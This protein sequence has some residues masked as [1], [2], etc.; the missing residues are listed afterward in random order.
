[1]LL[2]ANTP[3]VIPVKPMP[4]LF[5]VPPCRENEPVLFRAF[6]LINNSHP[7]ASTLSAPPLHVVIQAGSDALV[8]AGCVLRID[9]TTPATSPASNSP[10]HTG[11]S[12]KYHSSRLSALMT[13]VCTFADSCPPPPSL[14]SLTLHPVIFCSPF[15]S[16][17]I[18]SIGSME[19]MG[20]AGAAQA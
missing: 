11:P 17:Q 19:S 15:R 20:T 9:Q 2:P 7:Q 10:L 16:L 8:R 1:M 3:T 14:C 6:I 12:K 5:P 18:S 4:D 13:A